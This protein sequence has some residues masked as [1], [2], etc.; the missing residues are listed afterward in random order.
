MENTSIMDRIKTIEDAFEATGRPKVDFSNL[1]EDLRE[2]FEGQYNAVVLTEAL[3]QG[4]KPDWDKW[5]ERKYRPWFNMSP[6]A[7]GFGGT[8]YD[9]SYANAGTGSRLCNP[10]R[11]LAIYSAEQ[12]KDIWKK[13]QLG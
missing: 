1:P 10:T 3:N 6:S 7:F 12:F 9:D 11:E 2:Y 8:G 13:V 5:G 4:F